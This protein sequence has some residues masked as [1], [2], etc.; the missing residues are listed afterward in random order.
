MENKMRYVLV[1]LALVICGLTGAA[2]AGRAK[3][4]VILVMT[5]DQ[6]YG[7]RTGQRPQLNGHSA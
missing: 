6:G 4:N 5:D 1:V 7:D 3:P 2:W